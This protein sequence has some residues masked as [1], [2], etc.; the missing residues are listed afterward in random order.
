MNDRNGRDNSSR[1]PD[2]SDRLDELWSA[3]IETATDL[4]RSLVGLPMFYRHQIPTV[5]TNTATTTT[6][7]SSNT[8]TSVFAEPCVLL[9]GM[10]CFFPNRPIDDDL[11]F[12]PLRSETRPV[13]VLDY[14]TIGLIEF[15]SLV[16]WMTVKPSARWGPEYSTPFITGYGPFTHFWSYRHDSLPGHNLVRRFPGTFGWPGLFDE[17]SPLANR[18]EH[19]RTRTP[20]DSPLLSQPGQNVLSTEFSTQ[21]ERRDGT[22]V[23]TE[24]TKETQIK[25]NPDG[26]KTEEVTITERFEDGSVKTTHTVHTIPADQSPFHGAGVVTGTH[27]EV[28]SSLPDEGS[29]AKDDMPRKG[30]WTW[31]WTRK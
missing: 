16:P 18:F 3:V 15:P 4:T 31:F 12:T 8:R 21:R 27:D 23:S 22:V 14:F 28:P 19:A 1:P 29:Q 6:D 11:L 26:S 30:D 24:T 25:R 20:V 17:F 13:S 2:D 5:V 7:E 9:P 10:S